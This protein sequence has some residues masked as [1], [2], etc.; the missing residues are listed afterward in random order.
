MSFLYNLGASLQFI[1]F[2]KQQ[3]QAMHA[4]ID[5]K[6]IS[7]DKTDDF[8]RQA[9]ELERTLG[10]QTYAQ[11]LGRYHSAKKSLIVV[12]SI[13]L[14]IALII[15][16]LSMFGPTS[17]MIKA[18]TAQIMSD[19]M[20]FIT[21]ISIVAGVLLVGIIAAHFYIRSLEKNLLGKNLSTLW[22]KILQRWAPDL[23]AKHPVTEIAPEGIAQLVAVQMKIQD[24][25]LALN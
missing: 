18:A 13:I 25:D 23:A 15:Y 6:Q 22:S 9:T 16:A 14:A 1:H 24:V 5:A 19:F 11:S 7:I 4:L 2:A 17:A 10:D 21:T 3:L 8:F 20:L 12:A